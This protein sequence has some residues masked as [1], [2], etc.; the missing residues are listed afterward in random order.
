MKRIY[1]FIL[2][3]CVLSAG[4]VAQ[5][6]TEPFTI[7]VNGFSPEF[8]PM[9]HRTHFV[10]GVRANPT[11]DE[12]LYFLSPTQFTL[13]R[14]LGANMIASVLFP[15]SV[16]TT[17]EPNVVHQICDSAAPAWQSNPLRVTV[18]DFGLSD[19]LAGER[20]MLHPESALDFEN[21]G[22]FQQ[23]EGLD[24]NN[25]PIPSANLA[26][27]LEAAAPANRCLRI[28]PSMGQ[29]S[30]VDTARK[31]ELS[32]FR[33][34][35]SAGKQDA[36]AASGLY[37]LSATVQLEGALADPESDIPMMNVDI[38]SVDPADT[39]QRII[40]SFSLRERQFF[41]SGSPVTHPIEIVLGGIQVRESADTVVY[42]V[43]DNFV[44]DAWTD[45]TLAD[46]EKLV[47]NPEYYNT[48]V[49][50][51]KID[52][53]DI[54]V[55]C[56]T[57]EQ[58][59][60]L[61][62]IC[63]TSPR[64]FAMFYP[65]DPLV[66]EGGALEAWR[67]T[68][69]SVHQRLDALLTDGGKAGGVLPPLRFI[70]GPEQGRRSGQWT[71]TSVMEQLLDSASAGDVHL[72]C[73]L[74]YSE[75]PGISAAFSRHFASGYYSYPIPA[76][77][78]RPVYPESTPGMYYHK[79]NR[80][81][82]R[83]FAET[84]LQFRKHS[85]TRQQLSNVH[86]W[87]PFIQNHTNL[88]ED[89]VVQKWSSWDGDPLREPTSA[90]L[91]IQ[92]NIPLAFGA[93]GVMLYAFISA[94]WITTH[95]FWPPDELTWAND[96]ASGHPFS[97]PNA[98]T[99]G[100]VDENLQPRNLDYNG[101][102]KWDSTAAYFHTFLQPI[103]DFIKQNL[104][105]QQAKIWSL[106]YIGDAG[107]NE[108]VTKVLGM[109]QDAPVPIDP[110][111]STFV[112]V[113]EFEH[114][115]TGARYLFVVNGRT[116]RTE[117]DRHIVVK[118]QP[119]GDNAYWKV[120][121][122]VTND[123]WFV[124]ANSSPDTVT[125]AN[126]FVD[127]FRPGE[128]A[129]YLVEPSSFHWTG[130]ETLHMP[131]N[132]FIEPSASLELD[133]VTMTFPPG[134][135]LYTE[136]TLLASGSTF[137]CADSEGHWDGIF[138][139]NGGSVTL[140][141]ACSVDGARAGVGPGSTLSLDEQTV[142]TNTCDTCAVLNALGGSITSAGTF[143]Q[144]PSNGVYLATWYGGAV[145]L[146]SDSAWVVGTPDTNTGIWNAGGTVVCTRTR[147]YD[148]FYGIVGTDL[149]DTYGWESWQE[150]GLNRIHAGMIALA[151]D[152]EAT[153]DLG[154]DACK[155]NSVHVENIDP[156]YHIVNNNSSLSVWADSVYWSHGSSQYFWANPKTTGTGQNSVEDPLQNDPVPLTGRVPV[157][158]KQSSL[159][160]TGS[161]RRDVR[162]AVERGQGQ[163]LRQVLSTAL[164]NTTRI[165]TIV[166]LSE[167]AFW[168]RRYNMRDLRDT[169]YSVLLG[170]QDMESKLLAVD[171]AIQDSLFG[172]AIEILDAYSFAGSAS[173]QSRS[174][175][176]KA[177][178]HPLCGEGGY[179]R[180]LAAL[181]S[182]RSLIGN[183]RRF[184]SFFELYPKLY[185]GLN[186]NERVTVP[187]RS[188][189]GLL[190]RILPEGIEV[191][192]N[193]PNPFSD[194]TSFTFKLGEDRH[195]RLAVYDAMG[196]EVA[197]VTDADYSRGVHSVVLRS[198]GLPTGI[199]FY[200]LRTARGVI[201]R[202]ML[203]MR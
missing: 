121:N 41:A 118:L 31:L 18:Q 109:R 134:K 53:L 39:T 175:L 142:F 115:T 44:N 161:W 98:G 56:G 49:V 70:F 152:G 170:R 11:P 22:N 199:Y 36:C 42:F 93:D 192:A 65:N 9:L 140:T 174:L 160:T 5:A 60:L 72:Y 99:L 68:R 27:P 78:I 47:P 182:A 79:L 55:S 107:N 149:G 112:I 117:G 69:G 45:T 173:L 196:R 103:G 101:E 92:C 62:A 17:I 64:T 186:H 51:R 171:L 26:A 24:F 135:G 148:Q 163:L 169:V 28:E 128:A 66:A 147:L 89:S 158:S 67:N 136:G 139:R 172:D 13:A 141:D 91:R 113:S 187:K 105:W 183:D 165:P 40:L 37:L 83:G 159:M 48:A 133:G 76:S 30:E 150:P 153:I 20:I 130:G 143:A 197:V 111:D 58:T 125:V 120:T 8:H 23:F 38:V 179:M 156:G 57:S 193:Y 15:D 32:V 106:Q 94:P 61:D 97:D 82:I 21:R 127:Y 129:L 145:S 180:G 85:E 46:H 123:T 155:R 146:N 184:R 157:L 116:H 25:L 81:N 194:L 33:E 86:P 114:R 195:V 154:D 102:H 63:L 177:V 178:V 7:G 126:G 138:A 198:G 73:A 104:D 110:P 190:D 168:A 181:D 74:G 188:E 29:I 164:N 166:D 12:R 34:W 144:T 108:T 14:D 100:L 176:R 77:Y 201:Q 52:R 203:L 75:S 167:I 137:H 131:G 59:L 71:Q 43:A 10:Q 84:A 132:L 6:Q 35:W 189:R 185:S 191:W 96:A 162:S 95:P 90:E 50:S 88:Y 16:L 54:R 200:R 19:L 122:I 2:A 202:K 87:I 124:S 80:P 151:V 119:G 1:P 3:A 4:V